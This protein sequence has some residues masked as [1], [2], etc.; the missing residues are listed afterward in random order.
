M[1]KATPVKHEPSDDFL[2]YGS[3]ADRK[4]HIGNQTVLIATGAQSTPAVASSL[5]KAKVASALGDDTQIRKW[6][7]LSEGLNTLY[8]LPKLA[9]P[10]VWTDWFRTFQLVVTLTDSDYLF[11]EVE[12]SQR[13][14]QC[15]FHAARVSW[16]RRYIFASIAHIPPTSI[17]T[18]PKDTVVWLSKRYEPFAGIEAMRTWSEIADLSLSGS[19]RPVNDLLNQIATLKER[20][21]NADLGVSNDI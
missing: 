19:D 8:K 17:P 7:S 1:S 3:D 9:N 14:Q 16:F 6:E 4:P 5:A 12:V 21:T 2:G 13:I 15:Q 10:E 20:A 11:S 18:E